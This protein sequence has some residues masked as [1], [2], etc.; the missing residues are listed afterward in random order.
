MTLDQLINILVTI[1]LIEMMVTVGLQVTLTELLGVARSWRLVT[2]AALA[3]YVLVPAFTVGLLL[4]FQP[5]PMVAAGFLILAVCPGAPF[6]P[7]ITALA[8]GNVP[9][10][11]GLMVL[12]AGSSALLAPLLLPYLLLLVSGGEPLNVEATRIAGTLLVSQLLPLGV[13]LS[14]RQWRPRLAEWL[15]KPANQ[16]GKVLGLL[17][18]VFILV[19]HY[20]LLAEIRPRGLAGMLALLIASWVAGLLLGGP[21]SENRKAMT[22]TTSLRN[23]GVGLVIVTGSFPGSPALTATLV[24]GLIEI[25]G[26]LLLALVWSRRGTA[27][28]R[29]K[30]KGEV[31]PLATDTEP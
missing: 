3:N 24:Y 2:R 25:V 19:G 30:G 5:H 21:G 31:E 20:D 17:T 18:V 10:A 12:L 8:R 27:I 4:L 6:G 11:V 16:V 13:G 29:S 22:L 28:F 15:K 7:P 1:T 14:L 26:S 23:V 9:V